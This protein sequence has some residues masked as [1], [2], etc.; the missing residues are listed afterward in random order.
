MASVACMLC[1][2]VSDRLAQPHECAP[3]QVMQMLVT[4]LIN[5][6]LQV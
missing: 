3:Y 5:G 1:I 2:Y 4:A 6:N